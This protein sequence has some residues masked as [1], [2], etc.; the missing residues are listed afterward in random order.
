M[1]KIL[2]LRLI[3]L[4]AFSLSPVDMTSAASWRELLNQADFLEKAQDPDSA[5]VILKGALKGAATDLGETDTTVALILQ[6]I[7]VD[8][9]WAGNKR[10][11]DS[12]FKKALEIRERILD[13]LE[14]FLEPNHL[15]IAR[16]LDGLANLWD[17]W[18]DKE[19]KEERCL[20]RALAIRKEAL[21]AKHIDIARS[22]R[23]LAWN[24]HKQ[25]KPAEAESLYER[26][27]EII[28]DTLG[29]DHPDAVMTLKD[30][31]WECCFQGKYTEAELF[32][33]RAVAIAERYRGNDRL[34]LADVL[35]MKASCYERQ[36][37]IREGV[38]LRS[39]S[40][41]IRD[42]VLGNDHPDLL[43]PITVLA[44]VY[45]RIND[46]TNAESL[47]HRAL[48]ISRETFG[49]DSPDYVFRLGQLSSY[50]WEAGKYDEV[51]NLKMN[52]LELL[53]S[54]YGLNDIRVTHQLGLLAAL[55][56]ELGNYS[57]AE[58]LLRKALVRIQEIF[59]PKHGYVAEYLADLAE[60]YE[61]QGKFQ[62]A[63]SAL[64]QAIDIF[65]KELGSSH[66][67]VLAYQLNLSVLYMKQCRDLEAESLYSHVL[68][69]CDSVKD[70]GGDLA[71]Y[72]DG[73]YSG[74]GIWDV[75]NLLGLHSWF[76][77]SIGD[78]WRALET[79]G[80]A[81]ERKRNSFQDAIS[82][83][84][85][86][87]A[88]TNC[89]SL[90]RYADTYFSFYFD[91]EL[92]DTAL[93]RRAADI[94]VASK[95]VVSDEIFRR[96]K[97]LQKLKAENTVSEVIELAKA[98]SDTKSRL[99][100]LFH[101]EIPRPTRK[102]LR[103]LSQFDSLINIITELK[104]KLTG[105]TASLDTL[106]ERQRISCEDIACALP[107]H[108]T[109]VEFVKYNYMCAKSDSG[110]PRYFAVIVRKRGAPRIV[111][112]GDA[113]VIDTIVGEY[114]S[115][116][117]SVIVSLRESL[118]HVLKSLDSIMSEEIKSRD[119]ME[120]EKTAREARDSII[121][122]IERQAQP[123]YEKLARELYD[124]VMYRIEPY[125]L[126]K[127]IVFVAPD[128]AL[129][130]VSIGTLMD[131]KRKYLVDNYPIHYLSAGRDLLRFQET[132]MPGSGLLAM[133]DPNFNA[134]QRSWWKYIYPGEL[135]SFPKTREEIESVCK[136]W[137]RNYGKELK[138]C[139]YDTGASEENFRRHVTGKRVIHLA[140]HGFYLPDTL[141]VSVQSPE[142]KELGPI[143]KQNP[144]LLSG[145]LLAGTKHQKGTASL[146][147][148]GWLTAEEVTPM[149]L[150]GVQMVVL[151]ACETG[152]G[153]IEANEGVY[154]LRR[155]FLMAGARA[156]VVSL[157]ELEDITAMEM[158]SKLYSRKRD[159][160]PK[161]MQE[162]AKDQ[163]ERHPPH[164]WS[165][166]S[167]IAIG[168]WR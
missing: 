91:S 110:I 30:M 53:E 41:R 64:N 119:Q 73:S 141:L 130:L 107:E 86:K 10:E 131:K 40:L 44:I 98:I 49:P 59:G 36:Q 123:D 163:K 167:F 103:Q 135:D 68:S 155:A 46:T 125:I 143:A 111:D 116:M 65:A 75:T 39:R 77:R 58:S 16:H 99:S 55:Y 95:G 83:L 50:Y 21:G 84:L 100:D 29:R 34:L 156:V 56:G 78:F 97:L 90:R 118:K 47:Y 42:I 142:L 31:A 7:A 166:G 151:S 165:W 137:E 138:V 96:Q 153:T 93:S 140:T 61:K 162:I 67:F 4:V 20:S 122:L 63:E 71:R 17:K 127:K 117:Y 85:E 94:A 133:G 1:K 43:L 160:L 126:G 105:H 150:S 101:A 106:S 57:D 54:R 5:I 89:L 79:A 27:L 69:I 128:G 102:E 148:D 48:D 120:Y 144:L 164:P 23:R 92:S 129:N 80:L 9:R 33:D 70:E 14:T 76:Y 161:M 108:S 149:D 22:L 157:W 134:T 121:C 24:Y 32:F 158:M 154:G 114:Q 35:D 51:L 25:G 19:G 45:S 81:F 168:D 37:R 2:G 124:S 12:L 139:L 145:L 72:S 66:R 3:W 136:Y 159:N 88:L 112:I 6:Q 82:I 74:R 8:T 11:A 28:E 146:G 104:S 115:H 152:L 38:K 87:D 60:L 62:E 18:W 147:D 26:A 13:S 132:E 113:S 15:A 109:L 52:Q